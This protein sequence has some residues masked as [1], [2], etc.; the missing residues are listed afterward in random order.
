VRKYGGR[1]DSLELMYAIEFLFEIKGIEFKKRHPEFIIPSAQ[2][3]LEYVKCEKSEKTKKKESDGINS[4]FHK[5]IAYIT[6]AI[7]NN[8]DFT[9]VAV[10][11]LAIVLYT[12]TT[13]VLQTAIECAYTLT[14]D[15]ICVKAAAHLK[16]DDGQKQMLKPYCYFFTHYLPKQYK[17]KEYLYTLG[18]D[19]M[20]KIIQV[21]PILCS[22]D[23]IIT[24]S[25]IVSLRI[26]QK[27]MKHIDYVFVSY[28]QVRT[29]THTSEEMEIRTKF[30]TP[31]IIV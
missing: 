24:A 5:F 21:I 6:P 1:R 27:L 28:I 3:F 18:V 26:G 7:G 12:F 10:V 14:M 9:N 19:S 4:L 8:R 23:D 30:P 20:E 2:E 13:E 11:V 16:T 25:D 22:S 29:G 15:Q 17:I 31:D